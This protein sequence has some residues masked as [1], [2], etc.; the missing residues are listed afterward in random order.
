MLMS[1]AYGSL[2]PVSGSITSA[3]VQLRHDLGNIGTS[4]VVA[5]ISVHGIWL[6]RI[7]KWVAILVEQFRNFLSDVESNH[8]HRWIKHFY[9]CVLSLN[10]RFQ[11]LESFEINFIALLWICRREMPSLVLVKDR[12]IAAII[13]PSSWMPTTFWYCMLSSQSSR[14][15]FLANSD[16]PPANF[17]RCNATVEVL[18]LDMLEAK[19]VILLKNTSQIDR[20]RDDSG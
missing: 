5:V 11:R 12:E 14:T 15:Q 18:M 16:E 9:S 10:W 4:R 17:D 3:V 13:L 2:S 1:V 19:H 6:V 7:S 20:S 8:W